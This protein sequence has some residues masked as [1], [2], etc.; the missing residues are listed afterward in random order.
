MIK[1]VSIPIELCLESRLARK[2]VDLWRK[3][4]QITQEECGLK[5]RVPDL[6]LAECRFTV[7]LDKTEKKCP[8]TIVMQYPN[9]WKQY[10]MSLDETTLRI[11]FHVNEDDLALVFNPGT[12][13]IQI[14]LSDEQLALIRGAVDRLKLQP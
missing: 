13:G 12:T 4:R 7:D 8:I 11:T 3:F 6:P 1:S 5:D 2:A 14:P 10:G 9:P